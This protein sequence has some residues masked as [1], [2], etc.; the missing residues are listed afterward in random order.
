MWACLSEA[1]GAA[2]GGPGQ[3][4]RGKIGGIGGM[5]KN[6]SREASQ[7]CRIQRDGE[8][9]E[10][11]RGVGLVEGYL[12]FGEVRDESAPSSEEGTSIPRSRRKVHHPFRKK[13]LRMS[14]GHGGAKEADGQRA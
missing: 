10:D 12:I 8:K 4:G 7:R 11:V 14:N 6:K 1:L 13:T 9:N 2:G 5:R 3:R